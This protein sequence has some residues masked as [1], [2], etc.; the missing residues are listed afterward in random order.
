MEQRRLLESL[1]GS[2][3]RVRRKTGTKTEADPYGMT[4]KRDSYEEHDDGHSGLAE[5]DRRTRRADRRTHQ[6]AGRSGK[7][8]R[9]TEAA[10]HVTGLRTGARDGTLRARKA[11]KP[12][13][14]HRRADRRRLHPHHRR[15]AHAAAARFV[16]EFEQKALACALFGG[17][18]RQL[19]RFWLGQNDDSFLT[20]EDTQ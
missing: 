6:Q 14:T 1:S 11:R 19:R 4:N 5:K 2:F 7:G 8:N 12:R 18:V 16:T 17:R 10:E 15:H 9:R 13:P 3:G 20:R